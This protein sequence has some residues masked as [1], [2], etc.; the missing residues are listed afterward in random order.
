MFEQLHLL[1]NSWSGSGCR[2]RL[3]TPPPTTKLVSDKMHRN[4]IE[5]RLTSGIRT[6]MEKLSIP[7]IFN[8]DAPRQCYEDKA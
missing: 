1:L 8:H 7:K 4:G 6:Q 2:N 3:E 5:T